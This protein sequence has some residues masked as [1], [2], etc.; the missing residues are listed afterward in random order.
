MTTPRYRAANNGASGHAELLL[1][2]ASELSRRIGGSVD[3]ADTEADDFEDRSLPR[4]RTEESRTSGIPGK[5]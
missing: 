2:A 3:P 5:E 1:A 4:S